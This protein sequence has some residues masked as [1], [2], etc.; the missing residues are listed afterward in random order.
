MIR[1]KRFAFTLVEML[2]VIAIIAILVGLLVPAVQ[3]VRETANIASCKNNLK[4]IGLG[5]LAHADKHGFFPDAGG[6]LSLG[7]TYVSGTPAV[8]PGRRSERAS[9][10]AARDSSI[11]AIAR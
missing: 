4:Q 2:V 8:T 3:Y 7:R 6:D 5:F 10:S 9:A 11:R 1:S